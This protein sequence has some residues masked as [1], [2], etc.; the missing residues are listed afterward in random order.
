MVTG[1]EQIYLDI[2][3]RLADCDF[4]EA[5]GRL[6]LNLLPDGT[7]SVN[8]LGR[9]YHITKN[10]VQPTDGNPVSVNNLSI[11]VYYTTSKGSGEPKYSY[12]MLGAFAKGGF[13]GNN[14]RSLKWMT[15]PLTHAFTGDIGKFR[16]IMDTLGGV[17]FEEEKPRRGQSVWLYFLL[18][19]IPCKIIYYE[20]DEEFPC[21]VKILLDDGAMQFLEFEQLA[22]LQGSLVRAITAAGKA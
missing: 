9:I 1:Y 3:G 15:A 20:A 14:D 18:P 11:L 13:S 6:G 5:A 8:F 16:A 4:S 10:G 21:E 12:R 7:L 19:K 17:A 22:F 2:V